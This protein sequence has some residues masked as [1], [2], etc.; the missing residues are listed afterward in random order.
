MQLSVYSP[1]D[2]HHYPYNVV[3]NGTEATE[4][5]MLYKRLPDSEEKR[6]LIEKKNSLKVTRYCCMKGYPFTE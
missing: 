4:I 2:T 1:D 5:V 6:K 3:T